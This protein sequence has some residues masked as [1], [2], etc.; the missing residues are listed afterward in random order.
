MP[1]WRVQRGTWAVAVPA[2]SLISPRHPTTISQSTKKLA[3]RSK[4]AISAKVSAASA[5]TPRLAPTGP[6]GNGPGA[7]AQMRQ[8]LGALMALRDGDFTAR[9]PAHWT[10][11]EGRIAEAFNQAI[12]HEDRIAREV[13]SLNTLDQLPSLMRVWLFR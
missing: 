7:D 13:D 9:L 3:S 11:V 5:A 12:A 1:A 4:R 10:G 6:A 8:I 2:R